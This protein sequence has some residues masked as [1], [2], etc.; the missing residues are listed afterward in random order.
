MSKK[1]FCICGL[2]KSPPWCDGSHASLGRSERS[3]STPLAFRDPRRP[4]R[5]S[6]LAMPTLDNEPLMDETANE[7]V[8]VTP[9]VVAPTATGHTAPA[10]SEVPM[11]LPI[12][13]SLALKDVEARI[14]AA[15]PGA[16]V[17]V[18]DMTGSGDHLDAQ[19]VWSGFEGKSLVAQ[20]RS[21]NQALAEELK[22]P[23]HALKLTTLTPEQ[24]A[25]KGLG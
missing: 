22:G 24:A 21:V 15:L 9:R 16:R 18:T 3:L 5:P 11:S 17:T 12:R 6:L 13:G 19:V 23:I 4:Q 10:L 20:H 25:Q 8:G 2:T 14:A 7:G 1:A